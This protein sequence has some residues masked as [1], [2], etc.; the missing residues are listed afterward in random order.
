MSLDPTIDETQRT[1][2][3]TRVERIRYVVS[4][5]P[6]TLR[7]GGCGNQC[8]TSPISTCSTP[9]VRRSASRNGHRMGRF[10]T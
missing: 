1:S 6:P 10:V 3:L 4:G 5:A 2:R 7:G 9:G 8:P